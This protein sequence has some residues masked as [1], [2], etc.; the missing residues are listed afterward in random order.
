MGLVARASRAQIA[1]S[2]ARL[3]DVPD[4]EDLR[5]PEVGLVMLRGRIAGSGA[6][7]NLGEATVARAAVRLPSGEIGF[8][9][10]LGRDIEKARLAALADALWA[11]EGRRTE[12][13]E[14][15]VAPLRAF[16]AEQDR[17]SARRTAATKVD[18]F[19]MTRG[20]DETA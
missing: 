15:L 20:E 18:F 4:F 17:A 8:S 5:A 2:L 11:D 13:E 14:K 9:Y 1:E 16:F 3:A 6:P 12:V 7:F 19:T 10:V